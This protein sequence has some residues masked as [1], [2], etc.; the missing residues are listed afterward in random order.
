MWDWKFQQW[1]IFIFKNPFYPV[2]VLIHFFIDLKDMIN[3]VGDDSKL[4]SFLSH[5]SAFFS[6]T[7]YMW[8]IL[9]FF[10]F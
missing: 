10:M 6:L 5:I 3:T 8:T 7:F 4:L 9:V 1:F 2:R